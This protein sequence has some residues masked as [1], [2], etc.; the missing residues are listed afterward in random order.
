[1]ASFEVSKIK[2]K[3]FPPDPSGVCIYCG[4]K[5][6][7]FSREHIIPSGL[8]GG[9]I[10]LQAS[11][12]SCRK[13]TQTFETTCL[14]KDMF[15]FRYHFDLIK[16]KYEIPDTVPLHLLA[17]GLGEVKYIPPKTNPNFL[18]L[19]F[20]HRPPGMISGGVPGQISPIT[21]QVFGNTAELKAQLEQQGQLHDIRNLF[22]LQ[23]FVRMLAKIAHSFLAG[24]LGLKNFKP[25]LPQ[26][27]L[28]DRCILGNYLVGN[29]TGDSTPP[30]NPKTLHQLGWAP[31]R[32]GNQWVAVVRIRLFAGCGPT[33]IYS[34]VAGAISREIQ[35]RHSLPD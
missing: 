13:I 23:A 34:I 12:E 30:S 4:A 26:L 5:G 28:D 1:V 17:Q 33:P 20:I 21:L 11:C 6:K 31:M 32:W 14:R 16:H 29:W 7:V 8:G 27:I 15:S 3:V 18:V 2:A 22:N 24:E 10:L 9:L 25:E 19:P 35:Q